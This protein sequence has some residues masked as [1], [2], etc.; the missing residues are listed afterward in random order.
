MEERRGSQGLPFEIPVQVYGRT[1]QKQPIRHVTAT[2]TVSLN[3]GL[4]EMQPRVKV[5]QKVLLVHSRTRMPRRP[6]RSI[7]RAPEGRG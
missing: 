6:D 3:G 4:L 1:P 2:M 7:S 5:R